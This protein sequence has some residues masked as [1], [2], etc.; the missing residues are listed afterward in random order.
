MKLNKIFNLLKTVNIVII[1]ASVIL[2]V[3]GFNLCFAEETASEGIK[4]VL[5]QKSMGIAF[6]AAALSTGLS[7]IAA[8]IAVAMVGSAAMGAITEKPEVMGKAI[9]FA[10]LAEGI[11]IYGLIVSIMIL[12]KF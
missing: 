2:L 9:I 10:G 11:G 5:D 12:F 6:I 7:T 3:F 1:L 4:T 8:G